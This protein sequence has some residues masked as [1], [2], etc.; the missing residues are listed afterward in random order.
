MKIS[1]LLKRNIAQRLL[2]ALVTV[3]PA[4]TWAVTLTDMQAIAL[5]DNAMELQ[6]SFDGPAPEA[7]GYS[8]EHPPRISIDLPFTRSDLPKYNDVNMHGTHGVTILES[9]SRT[10]LVIKLAD[11]MKFST[12]ASGRMLSIYIGDTQR[13][14][15]LAKQN[16]MLLRYQT[17]KEAFIL[18]DLIND[19][20]F[21]RG[22]EGE[23]NVIVSMDSGYI[24]VDITEQ[25][26]RIRLMFQGEV[27][28]AELRNRLDVMDFA[29]IV[30]YIDATIENGNSV[31]YIELNDQF[32][33]FVYQMDEILTVSVKEAER[34][35]VSRR[36]EEKVYN[37][38]QFL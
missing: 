29:T 21:Q 30:N 24:P 38:D 8:I 27:L 16:A 4:V 23:A 3:V 28:P 15:D 10:R 37:G 22:A 7:A 1:H 25:A 5:D 18:E 17:A 9:N 20:D 31:I 35:D 36:P 14:V 26:G 13:A 12:Q 19:I 2:A 6:L 11:P 33:Y 32:E 34:V